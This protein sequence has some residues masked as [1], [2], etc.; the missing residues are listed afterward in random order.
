MNAPVSEVDL[1]VK[2]RVI[3][4]G[5]ELSLNSTEKLIDIDEFRSYKKVV[6]PKILKKNFALETNFMKIFDIYNYCN[7]L[8]LKFA[9]SLGMS[10]FSKLAKL[11][12]TGFGEKKITKFDIDVIYKNMTNLHEKIDINAFYE[13]VEMLLIKSFKPDSKVKM[14]DRL[15]QLIQRFQTVLEAEKKKSKGPRGARRA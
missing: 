7:G 15:S 13:A 11:F 9:D 2:S 6:G 3:A 10:K 8:N 4:H 1:F 14:A 5:V 12:G